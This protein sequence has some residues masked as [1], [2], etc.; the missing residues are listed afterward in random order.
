MNWVSFEYSVGTVVY[1]FSLHIT[2]ERKET[3]QKLEV[4]LS[5]ISLF[6]IFL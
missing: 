5:F 2:A 6:V 4:K 1:L 3:E